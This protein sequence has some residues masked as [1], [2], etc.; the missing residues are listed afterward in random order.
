MINYPKNKTKELVLHSHL[1]LVRPP[2]TTA[3]AAALVQPVHTDILYRPYLTGPPVLPLAARSGCLVPAP[4]GEQCLLSKTARHASSSAWL[5]PPPS[6]SLL[7][8]PPSNPSSSLLPSLIQILNQVILA[9]AREAVPQPEK[10]RG[11]YVEAGAVKLQL[12]DLLGFFWCRLW[13]A[14]CTRDWWGT[15]WGLWTGAEEPWDARREISEDN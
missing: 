9:P 7:P 11:G 4:E 13:C 5:L 12:G 3:A 6:S 2:A 8:P 1:S 14:K 10:G 15:W